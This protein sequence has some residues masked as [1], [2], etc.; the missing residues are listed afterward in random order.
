M[1]EVK[2]LPD[3][4]LVVAP[5][6]QFVTGGRAEVF[7]QSLHDALRS[8]CRIVIVDLHEVVYIDSAGVRALVRGHTTAQRM[9]ATLALAALSPRVRRLMELT[10][11]DGILKIYESVDTAVAATTS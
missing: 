1:V 4:P 9:S 5:P 3:S 2:N 8:G 6:D 10:R 11:L 7:E